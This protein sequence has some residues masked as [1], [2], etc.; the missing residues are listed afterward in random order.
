LD[1]TT[2]EDLKKITSGSVRFGGCVVH[3]TENFTAYDYVLWQEQAAVQFDPRT[4]TGV[5]L[6]NLATYAG[7]EYG[8]EDSDAEVRRLY[9]S[10]MDKL[11]IIRDE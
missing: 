4:A 5:A 7:V 1:K 6:R 3:F 9:F 10:T 2:E 8:S 11:D